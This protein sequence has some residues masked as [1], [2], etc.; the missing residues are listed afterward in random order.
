MRIYSQFIH[1]IEQFISPFIQHPPLTKNI[2]FC[3]LFA[4][5][6]KLLNPVWLQLEHQFHFSFHGDDSSA[7]SAAH[8]RNAHAARPVFSKDRPEYC[9]RIPRIHTHTTHLLSKD[10]PMSECKGMLGIVSL[11]HS[12]LAHRKHRSSRYRLGCG[13]LSFNA[14]N[15]VID[16][17]TPQRLQLAKQ[18]H[19]IEAWI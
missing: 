16:R 5:S 6:F 2:I 4:I 15:P 3:N 1:Q 9:T 18:K 12:C 7:G 11:Q 14:T 17:H 8:F 10:S 19:K 13:Q